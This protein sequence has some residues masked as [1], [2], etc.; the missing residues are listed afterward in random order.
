MKNKSVWTHKWL[1]FFIVMSWVLFGFINHL[2]L[3]YVVSNKLYHCLLVSIFFGV[4]NY[5]VVSKFQDKS[6]KLELANKHLS[7]AVEKDG[8]TGLLN[9]RTL[10]L[11]IEA[12]SN[13]SSC[14]VIFSDID[15]FRKFNNDFGHEM[16]DRVLKEVSE[17][18]TNTVR[19][20]DRIYRYGGEEIVVL[21]KNCDKAAAK[22][23]AE[24]IR[25]RI[26]AIRIEPLPGI[27]ISIGI[28]S[29]P[30][31]TKTLS[32]IIK[33]ADMAMLFAKRCGKNNVQ[34]V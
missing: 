24:K 16:G 28:S 8:L 9:R 4:V 2:I 11:D 21:L 31:G 20:E 6:L 1:L 3:M 33:Q 17:V 29:Y 5:V 13:M 34:T 15:D 7:A 26:A 25:T 14:A 23:I 22:A 19:K 32:Q 27:T 10:E 30:D 18:I 12:I